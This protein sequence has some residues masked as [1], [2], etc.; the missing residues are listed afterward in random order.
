MLKNT[1]EEKN[2][3]KE[4]IRSFF[5][6]F[7]Y[8]PTVIIDKNNGGY[9]LLS[10]KQLE[11]CFDPFLPKV[12]NE[13][14]SLNARH[15]VRELTELRHIFCFIARSMNFKVKTIG[16]HLGGRDHTTVLHSVMVFKN[17]YE[18]D[19]TFREKYRRISNQIKQNYEPSIMESIDRTWN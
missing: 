12:Y 19:E 11:E 7:N 5:E 6:K 1:E 18:T 14:V 10:L 17:L 2:F 13:V 9:N 3:T 15:R 16:K 8:Y 4:F